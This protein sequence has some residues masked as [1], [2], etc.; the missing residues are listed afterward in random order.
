MTRRILLPVLVVLLL[1]RCTAQERCSTPENRIG[2]CINARN[3]PVVVQLLLQRPLTRDIQNYL[4]SLQCG[5][6]GTIP[7]VCC[8]QQSPLTPGTTSTETPRPQSGNIDVPEPPDVSN[9]PNLQLINDNSC[10]PVTSRKI[11]IGNKTELLEYPWM[12]LLA[13]D[14]GSDAPE[15]KCGGSLINKRYVLTAAHCVTGLSSGNSGFD[16]RIYS[17]GYPS[18]KLSSHLIVSFLFFHFAF[19]KFSVF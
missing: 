19:I 2:V 18:F 13:Y 14:T 1:Q 3:C 9:H 5:I 11:F 7:K 6:D 15:F 17:K 16:D 8:A 4:R 12:A 10:G